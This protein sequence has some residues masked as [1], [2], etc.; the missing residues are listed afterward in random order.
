M[1]QASKFSI[2]NW[3]IGHVMLDKFYF[4][5]Q[6]VFSESIPASFHGGGGNSQGD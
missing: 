1:T 6:Q 4:R 3:S 2:G 5:I